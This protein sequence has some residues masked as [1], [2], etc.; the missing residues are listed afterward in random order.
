MNNLSPDLL[1]AKSSE[2]GKLLTSE[3]WPWY[4]NYLVVRRA[5]QVCLLPERNLLR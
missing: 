2:L 4:V 1:K 3:H 5:A